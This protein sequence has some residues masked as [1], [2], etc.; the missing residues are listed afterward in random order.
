[1][2]T[3]GTIVTACALWLGLITALLVISESAR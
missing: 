1:M 2:L 3:L